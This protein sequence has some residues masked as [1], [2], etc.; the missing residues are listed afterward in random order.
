[1]VATGNKAHFVFFLVQRIIDIFLRIVNGLVAGHVELARTTRILCI[2]P[3]LYWD[4]I[5]VSPQTPSEKTVQQ[6]KP[7]FNFRESIKR[8]GRKC[9]AYRRCQSEVSYEGA[10]FHQS[11]FFL[12]RFFNPSRFWD[13]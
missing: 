6:C 1:M 5:D 10:S 3:T 7:V 8:I 12:S 11:N 13:P 2:S 4:I 9:L